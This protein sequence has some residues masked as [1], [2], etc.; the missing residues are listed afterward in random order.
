MFCK[1]YMV[2]TFPSEITS[3]K[4]THEYF[5]DSHLVVEWVAEWVAEWVVEWVDLWVV[6]SKL[7]QL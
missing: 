7:S 3:H 1:M 5:K 6:V 4:M 2:S